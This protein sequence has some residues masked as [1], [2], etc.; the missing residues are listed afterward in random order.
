MHERR[1][2]LYLAT[3]PFDVHCRGHFGRKQLDDDASAQRVV[4]GEVIES[5]D[6]VSA[7]GAWQYTASQTVSGTE[8]VTVRAT[9]WDRPGHTGMLEQAWP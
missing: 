2:E 9:A 5:G 3:E 1:G 7:D 6:A 8:K 4:S